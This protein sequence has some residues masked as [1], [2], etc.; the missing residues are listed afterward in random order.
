VPN[1]CRLIK[2]ATR[3]F[4]PTKDLVADALNATPVRLTDM[5]LDA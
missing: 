5:F 4:F 2:D 3:C 1:D